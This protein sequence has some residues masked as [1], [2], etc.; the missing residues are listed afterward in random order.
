MKQ[1]R[2]T[3]FAIA[4]L[5]ATAV[6]L[7]MPAQASASAEGSFSRTL[8]VAGGTDVDVNVTTGSGNITVRTG[9]ADTVQIYAHIHAGNDWS[10][11]SAEEKVRRIEANPPIEQMGS[12]I[13]IGRIE[14]HELRQNVAIDYELTVPAKTR[15]HSQT[16]SGDQ[17]VSGIQA[18][19]R[20]QT[21]SGNLTLSNIGLANSLTQLRAESGSGD[22]DVSNANGRMYVSTGSGNIRTSNVAGAFV[23][24]SGSGDIRLDQ[25]GAGEVKVETGS[26]NVVAKG[27]NG[28]LSVST[29]SGDVEITGQQKGDW[30]L[31]AGSGN[32]RVH[33][34]GEPS[35]DLDAHTSSGSI[36]VNFPVTMQG[37]FRKNE[38]RGKVRN[39]GSLVKVRTGSGDIMFQ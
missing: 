13:R 16:G 22:I 3:T 38:L 4:I 33:L 1:L 24:S 2:L 17:K 23:G 32:V 39:G 7:A 10:G 19:V 34:N 27:V 25:T 35:F 20:V 8:K 29:G 37:S 18:D 31:T 12:L 26:G 5:I 28:P 14:D 6:T 15:L 21:G 36:D 30:S 9:A 11:L